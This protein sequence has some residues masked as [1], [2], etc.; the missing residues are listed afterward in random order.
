MLGTTKTRVSPVANRCSEL[1][2]VSIQTQVFDVLLVITEHGPG[3]VHSV[4]DPSPLCLEEVPS[5]ANV[6]YLGKQ[7]GKGCHDSADAAF[8]T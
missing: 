6:E 7:F 1:G 5:Q 8:K 2:I 4:D 3:L